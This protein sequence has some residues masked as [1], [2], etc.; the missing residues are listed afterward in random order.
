MGQLSKTDALWRNKAAEMLYLGR[1]ESFNRFF[2]GLVTPKLP[3]HWAD[4]YYDT[5]PDRELTA[6]EQEAA[7]LRYR[8]TCKGMPFSQVR[9]PSKERYPWTGIPELIWALLSPERSVLDAVRLHDAALECTTTDEQIDY[10]LSYFRFLVK[11]G[12]LEEVK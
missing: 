3:D 4:S 9:V 6:M 5:L 1:I 10:Y 11:Y 12:Y 7:K 8:N 2:P